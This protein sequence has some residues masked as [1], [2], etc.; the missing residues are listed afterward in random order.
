MW[1]VG[2]VAAVLVSVASALGYLEWWQ[3]RALDLLQQLQGR[4]PPHDVRLVII[5]DAVFEGLG[6]R[7]PLSRQYLA[8]VVRG[9]ARSGA[10][11]VGIDVTLTTP[12][13]LDDDA[14]LAAAIHQFP[15][16]P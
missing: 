2:L 5:D 11:V 6:R 12:T 9:L 10:A 1:A 8:R 15:R 16:T 13:T 14:A 7:Q 3:V 4:E